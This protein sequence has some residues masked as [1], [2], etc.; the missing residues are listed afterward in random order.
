[1]IY[2]ISAAHQISL[3][4]VCLCVFCGCY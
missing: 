2:Y 1:M 3:V 4:L